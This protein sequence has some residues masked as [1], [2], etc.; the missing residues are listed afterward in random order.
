MTPR[1]SHVIYAVALAAGIFM[2]YAFGHYGS[3]IQVKARLV[4]Y[5]NF[6]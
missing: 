5:G 1:L 6:V 2:P 4:S 3:A